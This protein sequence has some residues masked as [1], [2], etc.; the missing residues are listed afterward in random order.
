V[1]ISK[2][3][4]ISRPESLCS[5]RSVSSFAMPVFGLVLFLL[6]AWPNQAGAQSGFTVSTIGTTATQAILAYAA[7]ID[8]ACGIQVSESA[9][10]TPLVHDVDSSLFAQSNLD[11]RQGS[12][13]SGRS[14]VVVVGK[15]TAELAPDG[16]TY[17]RALQTNTLHYYKVTCGAAMAS[18]TFTTANIPLGMTYSDLPQIDPANPGAY[19]V[20]TPPAL[21]SGVVVDPHTGALI[22]PL[23]MTQDLPNGLGAFLAWGGFVRMCGPNLVGPGPGFL[24]G[25]FN[26]NGWGLIYYVIPSTGEVR[27]LGDYPSAY[28]SSTPSTTN[29][30]R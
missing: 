4:R 2:Q 20:P 13:V 12:L 9:N 7:P 11:S 25:M 29:F 26:N 8:G 27:Y 18:G 15:R 30:I 22:K 17:S 5:D 10:Y 21:R 23:S 24:C 19:L 6:G 14:R 3:T 1:R 28:P 16:T